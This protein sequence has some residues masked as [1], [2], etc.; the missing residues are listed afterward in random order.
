MGGCQRKKLSRMEGRKVGK[1]SRIVAKE[2]GINDIITYTKKETREQSREPMVPYRGIIKRQRQ[3]WKMNK[4]SLTSLSY[5]NIISFCRVFGFYL[6]SRRPDTI[7]LSPVT[8]FTLGRLPMCYE[9][10][11]NNFFRNTGS[12]YIYIHIYICVC[13]CVCVCR[14]Y[15]VKSSKVAN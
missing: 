9:Y 12:I 10:G 3:R 13:V 1:R 14:A 8:L 11:G 5:L 2:M 6:G 4:H 15:S 7:L